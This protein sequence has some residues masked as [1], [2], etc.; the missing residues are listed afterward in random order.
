MKQR[1]HTGCGCKRCRSGKDK[2]TR[3]FFHRMMRRFYKKQLQTDGEI[4]HTDKSIGY[5][6]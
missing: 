6:D 4:T 5:T 1:I 3:N 2:Q